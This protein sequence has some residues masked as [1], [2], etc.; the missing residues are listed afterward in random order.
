MN[1][2]VWALAALVAME[3][4]PLTTFIL[5]ALLLVG[6]TVGTMEGGHAS[7]GS[8]GGGGK[9]KGRGKR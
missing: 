8:G 9:G 1:Y 2:A 5:L 6:W 7:S 4:Y 3:Y